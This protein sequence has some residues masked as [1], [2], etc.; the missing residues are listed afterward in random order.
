MI[1]KKLGLIVNPIAGIGGRVGLKGSDG[2]EIRRKALAMGAMPESHN[3]AVLAI[4]RLKPLKNAF[5]IITYP[6]EMGAD[7]ANECK[8]NT[9]VIGSIKPGQTTA[10][11]SMQAARQMLRKNV[12]L[13]LFAGGDG[14]ARDIYDAIGQELPV[15]GIPSGVKIHSAVFA[16]NPLNAGEIAAQFLLTNDIS[17]R[18]AEV[19]DIDESSLQDGILSSKLYGYLDVPN[20]KRQLQ[21]LKTTSRP[22]EP[23]ALMEIAQHVV[24]N[25]R[26]DLLYIVAPG[27]TTR[28]I[29]SM[30]GLQKTLL[31]VD[32]I[33]NRKLLAVDVNE[34]QLIELL[35]KWEAKI[36]ISPIGGQ[37]FLFG[38]GNQQ[39]SPKVIRRVGADNIIVIS[40]TEKI[41]LL[42]SRPLLVDTGD[43]QVDIMLTGYVRVL[44]GRNESIM[45]RV[46]S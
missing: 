30:L 25:M 1:K 40:S 34:S 29:N 22:E 15:L 13:L 31:G 43:P 8:L 36:I 14:T 24:K 46:S 35:D 18:E 33:K 7:A 37:G 28:A 32:V 19:M 12:K 41:E 6:S 20:I 45:Y 2:L 38:R 10:Q 21:G 42:S 3:R 39:I 26:D 44:T 4:K 27:T 5:E 11:D 23:A 9:T 17:T 16:I